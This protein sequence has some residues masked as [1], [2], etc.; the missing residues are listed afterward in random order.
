MTTAFQIFALP[1]VTNIDSSVRVTPG[2]KA[3]FYQTGTTTPQN[4]FTDSALTIPSA[5]PVVADANGVFPVVYL[6]PTLIYKLTLTTSADV[7]IY[8]ADPVNDQLLSQALLGLYLYPRTAAEIASGVTPTFYNYPTYPGYNIQR[9]GAALANSSAANLIALNK[10]IAVAQASSGA[11]A[12]GAVK[13]LIPGECHYGYKF[14][15]I[16]TWPQINSGSVPITVID[17]SQGDTYDTYPTRY[18]GQQIRHFF[19]TPQTTSPGQ[20]NGNGFIINANWHPY[21]QVGNSSS[22]PVPTVGA[23]DNLR[24]SYELNWQGLAAWRNGQGTLTGAG[25]IPAQM[26]NYT[27]ERNPAAAATINFTAA[28]GA[29]ATAATLAAAATIYTDATGK[30][31]GY[32]LSVFVTF[33][34]G[35][36]RSVNFTN[37][38]AA[39]TWSAALTGTGQTNLSV[40]ASSSSLIIDYLTLNWM[41]GTGGNDATQANYRFKALVDGY[42][43]FMIE[44]LSDPCYF[45]MRDQTGAAND[46]VLKNNA[47]DYIVNIPTQGDATKVS[48][49]DRTFTTLGRWVGTRKSVT[50]SASMTIDTSSGQWFSIVATNGVAFTINAPT[51]PLDGQRITI[52]LSNTSGGALGAATFNAVF[53]MSAWTNPANGFERSIDFEYDGANWRQVSQTGVDVPN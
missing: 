37:G 47:G 41:V 24:A 1:K 25:F 40:G 44:S 48:K 11:A 32:S 33:S 10:A 42:Y 13:I 49:A 26:L 22:Y 4:T 52:K 2:A 17:E 5:N 39:V 16:T 8:T 31:L 43:T 27:I 12:L 9:Y 3:W 35:Q 50:Y 36:T 23:T 14:T 53:K 28:L 21:F 20:H 19:Y 30:W 46:V 34:D 38:S 45:I 6:D 29:A 15:D 51:N 7:L 18:D